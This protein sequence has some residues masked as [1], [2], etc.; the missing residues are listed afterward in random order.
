MYFSKSS[1]HC[2]RLV[3]LYSRSWWPKI[4]KQYDFL[5]N[6]ILSWTTRNTVRGL[7]L[8]ITLF[9]NN[10][11]ISP[12]FVKSVGQ[13]GHSK[14][15]IVGPWNRYLKSNI[16]SVTRVIVFVTV[17]YLNACIRASL[18]IGEVTNILTFA[19]HSGQDE[20]LL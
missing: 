13:G 15:C 17:D 2:R 8:Y 16:M 4:V 3:C 7:K 14:A 11:C 1:F 19:V 5:N 18:T 20:G 12:K 10:A 9:N 6:I